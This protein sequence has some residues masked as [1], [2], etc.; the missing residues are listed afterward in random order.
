MPSGPCNLFTPSGMIS[1]LFPTQLC[2]FTASTHSCAHWTH[3]ISLSL[4]RNYVA[5]SFPFLP[6]IFIWQMPNWPVCLALL[7]AHQINAYCS[8]YKKISLLICLKIF[9]IH[10]IDENCVFSFRGSSSLLRERESYAATRR[11][12]ILRRDISSLLWRD[13][14]QLLNPW[15]WR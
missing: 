1:L 4:E 12:F 8:K 9:D 15:F 3:V 7:H 10:I 5:L 2:S 6:F 14:S 13:T 11:S